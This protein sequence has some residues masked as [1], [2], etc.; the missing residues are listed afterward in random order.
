MSEPQNRETAGADD[1]GVPGLT[2]ILSPEEFAQARQMPSD[3]QAD[4]PF[5]GDPPAP[6]PPKGKPKPPPAAPPD[7][8]GAMN[9]TTRTGTAAPNQS[10]ADRVGADILN[11]TVGAA[12]EHP[13]QTAALVGAG[14]AAPFLTGAYVAG[15][16]GADLAKFAAAKAALLA[17]RHEVPPDAIADVEASPAYQADKVSAAGSAFLLAAM[18]VA[19]K[20]IK[21][22]REVFPGAKPEPTAA[23]TIT[24]TPPTGGGPLET[25]AMRQQ[26]LREAAA[27]NTLDDAAIA[28]APHF[29]R[30]ATAIKTIF[31]PRDVSPAS[32]AAATEMQA[33]MGHSTG[34]MDRAAATMDQFR[35]FV[36]IL[37][38]DEQMAITHYMEG[39]QAQVDPV[40]QPVADALRAGYTGLAKELADRGLLNS[41]IE[42]Y[43]RHRWKDPEAAQAALGLDPTDALDA[44]KAQAAGR[45][46]LQGS[47]AFL[48][49]RSIPT[50]AEGIA[51]QLEP[52]TTNPIDNYLMH[53]NDVRKLLMAQDTW[54]AWD[55]LGLVKAVRVG[56]RPPT[57]YATVNDAIARIFGPRTMSVTLPEGAMVAFPEPRPSGVPEE[58]VLSAADVGLEEAPR[59]G[60][61]HPALPEGQRAL[62]AGP[63]AALASAAEPPRAVGRANSGVMAADN[64][65]A[66]RA[67]ADVASFQGRVMEPSDIGGRTFNTLTHKLYLPTEVARLAN[68]YLAPGLRGHA[69]YDLYA[70]ANNGLNRAQLGLSAFHLGMTTTDAN[71]SRTA[72]AMEQVQS[73]LASNDP[74]RALT[75]LAN[76]VASPAAGLGALAQGTV[77]DALN[78][79]RGLKDAP[80]SRNLAW[81][82]QPVDGVVTSVQRTTG[83]I[84]EAMF[85]KNVALGTGARLRDAYLDPTSPAAKGLVRIV[86]AMEDANFSP[87]QHRQWE[88]TAL[89][90]W[91]A[92]RRDGDVLGVVRH[93]PLAFLEAASKPMMEHIVPLQKV[94]VFAEL[95][96]HAL[97]NLPEGHTRLDYLRAMQ[98]VG[99][100]VD[101]RM[102]QLNYDNLF[103]HPVLKDLLMGTTRSVGWNLGTAREVGGGTLDLAKSLADTDRPLSHRAAYVAA[104]AMTVGLYGATYQLL[105]TGE[106]PR[107]QKDLWM[108][109]TG[110]VDAD[111]N[112]QRVLWPAYSRDVLAFTGHPLNTITN[113]MSPLLSMMVQGWQ[114][115]DFYGDKI[116]HWTNDM[117]LGEDVS[118]DQAAF[119]HSL[120]ETAR[121]VGRQVVPF[122][123]SNMQEQAKR[124]DST[125]AT[126]IGTYFGLAPAKRADVRGPGQNLMAD[127]AADR[128]SPALTPDQREGKNAKAAIL[129][130]MRTYLEA[131]AKTNGATRGAAANDATEAGNRMAA[132][133]RGA[134]QDGTLTERQV[135]RMMKD[136]Q[137]TP[138]QVRF[139]GLPLADAERVYAVAD[140]HEKALFSP[141]LAIKRERAQE[142]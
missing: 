39:G 38:G 73:A 42:N 134:L 95:A 121:Y 88:G 108:P 13:V 131:V 11:K 116:T 61:G 107:D 28:L 51:A 103:W 40:M 50:Y 122:S 78:A 20:G 64:Q 137:M 56:D 31:S 112:E 128:G 110:E 41:F 26:R 133:V 124:G 53:V 70:G 29:D 132:A 91:F 23:G 79:L 57:G 115:R 48:K 19:A 71:I 75:G 30:V 81:W 77:G 17:V 47:K 55:E 109:R 105:R 68:N 72:L 69:A 15:S 98:E 126:R 142:P 111:G 83:R 92:A 52:V 60:A 90:E 138:A 74:A 36:D 7:A 54:K 25:A 44:A 86:Q 8:T 93:T 58:T 43:V 21:E 12:V 102:G 45:R 66:S 2:R 32:T 24:A 85:P 120:N 127:L 117:P 89:H 96:E 63:G 22:I 67:T 100:T 106:A 82:D 140:P 1:Q 76:A 3:A 46:P 125:A 114:N 18:P 6:T 14:F 16:M 139:Y 34:I 104:L 80:P 101:N 27:K 33:A 4:M 49:Q 136:A 123:I 113:K 99:A 62:P 59:L 10:F 94:Q 35:R 87:F 5:T 84:I 135:K 65:G 141:L 130:S 9:P 37:P 118:K 119:L 129:Q 97:A